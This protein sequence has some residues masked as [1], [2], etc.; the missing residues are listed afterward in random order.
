MKLLIYV[1]ALTTVV[2]SCS[3]KKTMKTIMGRVYNPI[4]NLAI[5]DIEVVITD[6]TLC[7][8]LYGCGGFN[9]LAT[10]NSDSNGNYELEYEEGNIR[11]VSPYRATNYR[12][13]TPIVLIE[14]DS[15]IDI[16]LVP[17][18]S[19]QIKIKNV[20][21]FNDQDRLT[22]T[23]TYN[24]TVRYID[25]LPADSFYDYDFEY[26]F[27]GCMNQTLNKQDVLMGWRFYEGTVRKNGITTPFFDSV[28]VP[29]NEEKYWIL[30]Y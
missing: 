17:I 19:L 28:Y 9:H 20:N 12:P 30:E 26:S 11:A 13:T 25:D 24:E 3:K 29:E 23:R 15:E 14:N 8:D 22:I 1:L 5:Q 21:C 4:T 27:S 16:L 7:S 10:S 2:F 6:N 18:S